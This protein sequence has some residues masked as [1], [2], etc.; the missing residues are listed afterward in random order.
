MRKILAVL[1][2]FIIS[3]QSLSAQIIQGYDTVC[4][5]T[6]LQLTTTQTNANSFYWGFCSAYL[7]NAPQGS[8]I[9]AGTGLD[10]PRSTALAVDTNNGNNYVFVVNNGATNRELIRYDFGNSMANAPVAVNLGNFGGLININPK[11]L[12]LA[13]DGDGWHA[14]LAAGNGPAASQIVRFDFGA[15]LSAV[16][17]ATDLGNLG[18]LVINPQD[19]YIFEEAGNWHGFTNSGFTGDLIRFDF[20]ANLSNL[21]AVVNIPNIPLGLGLGFPTGFWPVLD[22]TNWHLFVANAITSSIVRL[23][24]GT[25]LTNLPIASTDLGNFGGLLTSPRD[26]SII[27]DCDS[28]Y[29]F[30]TNESEDNLVQL[31]FP[32]TITAAPTATALGNFGGFDGPIYLTHFKR[33]RDNIFAFTAN[34]ASN[35]LS[36]IEFNSCLVPDIKSSIFRTPPPITYSTPGVYNVYLVI[37][38]GLPTMQV[39][40]KLI[41]VIPTPL[42]TIQNDTLICKGDTIQIT[43]NG[44]LLTDI[45]WSPN[46]NM[47]PPT[48]DTQ[49]VRLWPRENFTYNIQM[50][51]VGGGC[52]IDTSVTVTVSQVDADAGE[53]RFVGDGSYTILGGPKL[54]YGQEYSYAWSP[55]TFLDNASIANPRSDPKNTQFYVLSVTNDS[56][57]CVVTDSVFVFN[58]CTD[59]NMPNAFNP[60]SDIHYNRRFGIMNNRIN[61]LNYFRI[62]NRWGNLVFETTNPA[63]KW[64]G[65]FENIPATSGTYVWM[66]DG[67][68]NNGKRIQKQ[69]TVFLV[70]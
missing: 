36:R 46:Y 18:G 65:N 34:N 14:F 23:D 51:F 3:I 31:N 13:E 67:E 26:I 7:N 44:Q 48:G 19:M 24:F 25:S 59:I 57:G 27:R 50:T 39:E 69:G 22:G 30:V 5:N 41:T 54:S 66:V 37:D 55:S 42:L 60:V 4:V 64:D 6:P 47:F 15:N 28:W 62:Y 58:E 16:P 21:P 17:T 9:A 61:K 68:C 1:G 12:W 11:G 33:S 2:I 43:A 32:G 53:D 45:M 29:A 49:T 70:R 63:I 35:S 40:C 52:V 10:A 56:S 38:E 20:G 8:S